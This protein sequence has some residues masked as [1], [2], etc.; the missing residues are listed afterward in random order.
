V[1][2][3][4]CLE[5]PAGH[6][7]PFTSASHCTACAN[8]T[9]SAE[10]GRIN[11]CNACDE[12][13][14]WYSGS[15]ATACVKCVGGFVNSHD[16]VGCGLGMYNDDGD[17]NRCKR[18]PAG[19]VN[20]NDS[21][22]RNESACRPCPHPLQ[23]ASADAKFC[24]TA[25]MGHVV[26]GARTGDV[27]CEVGTFRNESSSFFFCE[28]CPAGYFGA[29]E[30]RDRC[31]ICRVGTY[32]A[33]GGSTRC[34]VCGLGL[35]S[36]SDGATS[37]VSC[38]AGSVTKDNR[39]CTTCPANTRAFQSRSCEPCDDQTMSTPGSVSC[40]PCPDWTIYISPTTSAC[41]VCEA[42][43]YMYNSGDEGF[44][45]SPCAAGLHNPLRGSNSS[46][47][48]IM[49]GN[50]LIP[51]SNGQGAT[52]CKSCPAG[53]YER[54]NVMCEACPRGKFSRSGYVCTS[55]Y[56]GKN[57]LLNVNTT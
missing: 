6:Y 32:S 45:C 20:V 3:A 51:T 5:C 10:T 27:P 43:H 18:C 28:A 47:A 56:A 31:D 14:D 38:P 23:Y 46:K 40:W 13:G 2:G 24:V 21:F 42:G 11:E 4:E 39:I 41:D 9:F 33:G 34:A 15:A 54:L 49:C 53:Y 16:C 26:N 30:G 7:S 48:C 57:S 35:V 17:N 50:G 8:G 29:K 1:G 25:R 37:C 19:S 44:K 36:S 55:C 52:G 12:V 22:A